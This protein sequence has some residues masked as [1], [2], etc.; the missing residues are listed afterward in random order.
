ME[1]HE[2]IAPHLGRAL[3]AKPG[4]FLVWNQAVLH[5]GSLSSE[6]AEAPRISMALEFQRGD[7]APFREPLLDHE[8]LP[9]FSERVR[10]IAMQI[11]QYT[12]MYGVPPKHVQLGQFLNTA[13]LHDDA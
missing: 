8:T 11:L 6:F 1:G 4:D 2:P 7:I 10:L 12:H 5:W 9:T 3:P 13:Q